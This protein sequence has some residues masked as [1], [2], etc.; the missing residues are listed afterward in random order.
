MLQRQSQQRT[1][2]PKLKK[3]MDSPRGM[4]TLRHAIYKYLFLKK[5]REYIHTGEKVSLLCT[6]D[7]EQQ[8]KDEVKAADT[9]FYIN[10]FYVT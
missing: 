1:T 3:P 9:M 10:A 8:K 7:R 5:E 2:A 6:E 4:H